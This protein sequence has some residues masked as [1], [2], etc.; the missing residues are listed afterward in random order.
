MA[1]DIKT[2]SW[3]YDIHSFERWKPWVEKL[4]DRTDP[5]AVKHCAYAR[6]RLMEIQK[7]WPQYIKI[8]EIP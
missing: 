6:E 1:Y 3:T 7:R 8:D 4:K 5:F 2:S